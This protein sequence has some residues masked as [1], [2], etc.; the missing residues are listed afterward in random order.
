MNFLALHGFTQRG[1]MWDEVA[2]LAG[3]NW[4]APD[5]PGHG[6][7]PAC[8]WE[9]AVALV[10]GL[11]AGIAPPRCLVGYSMGGRLAL[12]VALDQPSLV[13]RLA[14][15]SAAAGIE[16]GADRQRRRAE[17]LALADRLEAMGVDAFVDEWLSRPLFA[18]L[19]ARPPEWRDADRKAR[20]GNDAS[21]LAAAL[22]LLGQ[23]AQPYLGDRLGSLPMPVL[24]AAGSEDRR[25]ADQAR[26]MG[27]LIAR[28]TVAEVAGAGHAVVG[29][30]PAELAA[31]LAA[32]AASG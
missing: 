19:A 13:D 27:G 29:E 14:L 30:R 24:L 9:E 28:A 17:D 15:L 1:S 7:R 4:S 5:L 10:G 26:R 16:E 2:A 23:G 3:G 6:G 18:G 8:S 21:G 12:A 32:W 22:R 25:Y 31:L 20:A 11:L